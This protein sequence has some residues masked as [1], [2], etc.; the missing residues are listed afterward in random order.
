[1]KSWIKENVWIIL[2]VLVIVVGI[3]AILGVFDKPKEPVVVNPP[4]A[5]MEAL[6]TEEDETTGAEDGANLGSEP[7]GEEVTAQNVTVEIKDLPKEEQERVTEQREAEQTAQEAAQQPPV[8]NNEN[9]EEPTPQP[10]PQPKVTSTSGTAGT[11]EINGSTVRAF[12]DVSELVG[13]KPVKPFE[14]IMVGGVNYGWT[15]TA[16]EDM[17]ATLTVGGEVNVIE[18]GLTGELVG[19]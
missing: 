17:S 1:M 11:A 16:W 6:R 13:L 3:L 19:Y 9:T 4:S 2:M 5:P 10:E 12:N 15:G 8:E 18:G 14:D 7:A